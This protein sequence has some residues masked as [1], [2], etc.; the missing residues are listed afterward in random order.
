MAN[1]KPIPVT[2]RSIDPTDKIL[3]RDRWDCN[4]GLQSDMF[5]DALKRAHAAQETEKSNEDPKNSKR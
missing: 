2:L 3:G 5:S 1:I 4:R